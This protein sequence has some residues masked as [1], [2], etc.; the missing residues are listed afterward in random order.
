MLQMNLRLQMGFGQGVISPPM[1]GC[2][3][4]YRGCGGFTSQEFE[5]FAHWG[6]GRSCATGLRDSDRGQGECNPR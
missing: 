4:G 2:V 5:T 3:F 6:G 1:P